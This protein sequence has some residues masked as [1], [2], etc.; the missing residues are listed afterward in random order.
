LYNFVVLN[1][2]FVDKTFTGVDGWTL[3]G[4]AGGRTNSDCGGVSLVGGFNVFG[5]GASA[6]K[7]FVIP[8]AHKRLRLTVQ[9]WKI[10]SW[11][12]EWLF[13]DVDGVKIFN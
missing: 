4:A 7:T 9:L 6:K 12:G 2:A 3:T 10:D 8:A 1:Q 13:I 11:D 5:A